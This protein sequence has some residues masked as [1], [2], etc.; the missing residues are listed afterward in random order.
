MRGRKLS[1]GLA[2]GTYVAAGV[3]FEPA[4][5]RAQGTEIITQPPRPTMH[6]TDTQHSEIQFISVLPCF[7]KI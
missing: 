5:I 6:M 1:E 3:E 2:Q 7:G 4:I